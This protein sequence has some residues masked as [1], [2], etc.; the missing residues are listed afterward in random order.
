MK[1]LE[2][3]IKGKFA[4]YRKIYTNSSS[5]TYGIP[6]KTTLVGMIAAILGL[7]R[8][9]YYETFDEDNVTIAIKKLN[10]TRK[11]IQTVNYFKATTMNEIIS[12][13]QHTQ[14]PFEILV[15]ENGENIEYALYLSLKDN[16][17]FNEV[18]RRIKQ[19][20]F[21]YLPY[22]GAAPF[23]CDIEYIG[24]YE[25]EFKHFEDFI[26]VRTVVNLNQIKEF[27]LDNFE[28][29]L[30]RERMPSQFSNERILKDAKTY[31]Y[32]DEGK[33]IELILYGEAIQLQ[34]GEIITLMWGARWNFIHIQTGYW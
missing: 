9:S 15:G 26:Q 24:I 27:K 31:I 19:K 6:P 21:Y 32:E 11:I 30:S 20:D 8:D 29:K 14:I 33:P 1:I 5:L 25:G 4:H 17:L 23:N 18:I 3:K 7:E 28:G 22:L 16:S 13:K 12:P 2:F 10:S 34:T